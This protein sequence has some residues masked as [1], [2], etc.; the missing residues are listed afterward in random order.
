MRELVNSGAVDGTGTAILYLNRHFELTDNIMLSDAPW[1]PIGTPQHPFRGRFRGNGFD[2]SRLVVNDDTALTDASGNVFAGLFGVVEGDSSVGA[3][4]IEN[5]TV[6][7][8]RI[9]LSNVITAGRNINAGFIAGKIDGD[10]FRSHLIV[11]ENSNVFHSSITITG[12]NTVHAGAAVGISQNMTFNNI[13][14][15]RLTTVT[16]RNAAT[17]Y[18][19][20]LFGS[21]DW[22][23]SGMVRIRGCAARVNVVLENIL[24]AAVAGG[25]VGKARGTT[26]EGNSIA[27]GNVRAEGSS[28]T[29]NTVRAGALIGVY[30]IARPGNIIVLQNVAA[31]G[32]VTANSTSR[33]YA[34]RLW[35]EV[36]VSGTVQRRIDGNIFGVGV[37]PSSRQP[38]A[39]G[40]HRHISNGESSEIA[41]LQP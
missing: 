19:G 26:I 33:S 2:I 10:P 28:S 38:I 30:D 37:L 11:V 31:F 39:T 13:V 40:T 8:S 3:N 7:Y 16:V 14:A 29:V 6:S 18:A 27:A 4:T 20:G 9:T 22:T 36:Q 24:V 23:A 21:V 35:G 41:N 12:G 17:V 1:I 25:L 32:N 34:G 5:L 15:E